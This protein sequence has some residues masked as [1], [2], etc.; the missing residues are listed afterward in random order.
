[1]DSLGPLVIVLLRCQ[2]ALDT[3]A[4]QHAPLA[5]RA[6]AA[7]GLAPRPPARALRQ[8]EAIRVRTLY[9]C[10]RVRTLCLCMHESAYAC[11]RVRVYATMS[12]VRACA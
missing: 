1:M 8:G 11:M 5:S 10:M 3:F 12:C 4:S 7:A 2:A 9:A 6:T